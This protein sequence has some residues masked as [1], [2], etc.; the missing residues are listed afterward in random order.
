MIWILLVLAILAIVGIYFV[1]DIYSK[2]AEIKRTVE[3][4]AKQYKAKPTK[5]GK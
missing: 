5:K 4:Q 1:A 2:I 3:A